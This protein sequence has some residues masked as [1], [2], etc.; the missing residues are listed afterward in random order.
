MRETL[1]EYRWVLNVYTFIIFLHIKNI[2]NWLFLIYYNNWIYKSINCL[3]RLQIY[4]ILL[5]QIF[6]EQNVIQNVFCF[7]EKS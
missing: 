3:V 5:S 6:I 2:Y 4:I 7:A 1:I